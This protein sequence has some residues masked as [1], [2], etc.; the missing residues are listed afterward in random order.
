M[1]CPVDYVPEA[2]NADLNQILA[3]LAKSDAGMPLFL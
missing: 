1:M 2:W 3:T